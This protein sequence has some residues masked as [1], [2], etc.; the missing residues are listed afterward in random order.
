MGAVER[1][2]RVSNSF[3]LVTVTGFVT[4]G[5][6]SSG[7]DEVRI[8]LGFIHR[9]CKSNRPAISGFTFNVWKG[10]ETP[11][12]CYF[13]ESYRNHPEL[14][15]A[16]VTELRSCKENCSTKLFHSPVVICDDV[17][18]LPNSV[19]ITFTCNRAY[20]DL[21]PISTTTSTTIRTTTTTRHTTT[22]PRPT[23]TIQIRS[24]TT[25]PRTTPTTTTT[26]ATR[27]PT[28][29][30][31]TTSSPTT[32][33]VVT[34]TEAATTGEWHVMSLVLKMPVTLDQSRIHV[35]GN[36]TYLLCGT[37]LIIYTQIMISFQV[38]KWTGCSVYPWEKSFWW[39]S[40]RKTALSQNAKLTD[41]VNVFKSE[42]MPLI[43][44]S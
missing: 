34:T 9:K 22:I 18:V 8:N 5:E 21:L 13:S 1:G 12:G 42:I 7:S 43:I 6:R 19:A 14:F 29:T 33:S 25:S 44:V 31:S 24:T 30:G 3:T 35:P 36:W 27:P 39:S 32:I 4:Q 15:N 11:S 17:E 28:E 20:Q 38:V 37:V 2:M 26:I 40:R 10:V 41:I 16:I 23:T